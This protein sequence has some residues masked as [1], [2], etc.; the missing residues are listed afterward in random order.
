MLEHDRADVLP[1]RP[2]RCERCGRLRD[3][4]APAASAAPLECVE[5]GA[6]SSD[7]RGWRAELAPDDAGFEEL[8]VPLYC[9]ACWARE[10]GPSDV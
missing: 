4:E 5:C 9:A 1:S 3:V 7:G 8:E 6:T 10:F 2:R